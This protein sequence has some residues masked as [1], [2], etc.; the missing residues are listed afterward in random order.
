MHT[1]VSI[2]MLCVIS[3][4]RQAYKE[5]VKHICKDQF[6][7]RILEQGKSVCEIICAMYKLD[8]LL[9]GE[10]AS[11][12][13]LAWITMKIR[14]P[15]GIVLNCRLAYP[16]VLPQPS[17]IRGAVFQQQLAHLCYRVYVHA[18]RY[19]WNNL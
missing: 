7:R 8:L 16:E 2:A 4:A 18:C 17:C 6:S 10:V 3:N 14:E 12:Y 19:K 1:H 11:I 13:K 15:N 9:T 5:R